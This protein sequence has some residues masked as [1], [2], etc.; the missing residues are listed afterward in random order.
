MATSGPSVRWVALMAGTL[1]FSCVEPQPKS[2][3]LPSLEDA[4]RQERKALV[5]FNAQRFNEECVAIDSALRVMGVDAQVLAGGV[6]LAKT[7]N[8][9]QEPTQRDWQPK[10]GDLVVWS[11]V[12]RSLDGDSLSV[13]E[14]EFTV[15]RDAVP[16]AFHE[17]AKHVGHRQDVEVWS[18][19]VS[20]FGVRGVPGE[21]P[22]YTPVH[23]EVNQRRSIRDTAWARS[24]MR[25]EVSELPW[26]ESFMLERDASARPE[27]LSEGLFVTVHSTRQA[28]LNMGDVALLRIRTS[29]VMGG[30]ETETDL[31]WPVGTPDQLVPALEKALAQ[32]PAASTLSIWST[33]NWAFGETGIPSAD[34][35][36]R[37]PVRFDV[38]VVPL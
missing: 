9:L 10:G 7:S 26:L 32:I 24:V 27:K 11:W 28:P 35:P 15:D 29:S 4:Q 8:A 6:R 36:P 34:I 21:I 25:G 12:A 22:P 13:G 30:R 1:L 14:D 16:Q 19:S 5:K 2:L 23:L 38:E 33:S 20:A 17:A 37:S 31:E 18:P 3:T